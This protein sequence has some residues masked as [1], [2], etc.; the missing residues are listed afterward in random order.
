MIITKFGHSCLLI[1]EGDARILFDP[2]SYS[3]GRQNSIT[4]LDAVLV[5]HEHPDHV[6]PESLKA[7]LANNPGAR[8][9]TNH[10]G[11]RVL[12]KEGITYVRVEDG[13]NINVKGVNIEGVGHDHALIHSSIPLVPNTGYFVANKFFYPGD[14]LTLPGRPVEILALPTA[15]P[16]GKISEV[17]DYALAVKPK[18]AIP[19]HDAIL[20]NP[21]MLHP[22]ITKILGD[23]GV[24]FKALEIGNAYE[25]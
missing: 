22:L 2:G 13:E 14:A 5:T 10:G 9:I 25:L 12:E 1:E 20:K 16:W 4:N 18:V 11:A 8:V 24:E 17:I 19:V 6:D 21:A 23:A 3:E 15:A 7:V